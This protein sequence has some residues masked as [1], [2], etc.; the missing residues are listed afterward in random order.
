MQAYKEFALIVILIPNRYSWSYLTR[1]WHN[2]S[3]PDS[4]FITKHF[5]H[6]R[7]L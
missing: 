2:T 7:D 1:R 4:A 3:V 6:T 5:V